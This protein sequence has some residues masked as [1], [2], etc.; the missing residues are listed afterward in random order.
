MS[1][2]HLFG[3]STF[4]FVHI[5]KNKVDI[6][7]IATVLSRL[8]RFKAHTPE[9]YYVAQHCVLCALYIEDQSYALEALL[10]D[11]V[12]SVMGDLPR[13][14]KNLIPEFEKLE[15]KL[16]K[17]VFAPTF[18]LPKKISK[19]VKEIDNMMLKAEQRD[20]FPDY[21]LENRYTYENVDHIPT[22]IPWSQEISKTV[23]LET[24]HKLQEK[25]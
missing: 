1:H 21:C 4:D 3:D 12:E 10:H 17:K 11:M 2:I 15:K 24:Y 19:Q 22:V 6:E 9:P 8:P 25:K 5:K 23:F 13:P 7:M 16:Y 20:F 18:G 14:L